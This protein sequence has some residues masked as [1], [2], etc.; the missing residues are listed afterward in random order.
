MNGKP[1]WKNDAYAIW[2]RQNVWFIG[3]LNEI[4]ND[5]AFIVAFND[6][7]GITDN[8][9]QWLYS[10]GNAFSLSDP[11]DIHIT[12]MDGKYIYRKRAII[13]RGFSLYLS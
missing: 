8:D 4:G 5:I 6:F 11:N 9:N 7:S 3:P 10:N 2:F 1:S 12:C 13:T